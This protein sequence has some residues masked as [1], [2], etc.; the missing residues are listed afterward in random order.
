MLRDGRS[1]VGRILVIGRARGSTVGSYIIYA[2][3]QNGKAPKAIIVAGEPDPIIIT[4]AI[5]AGIPLYK[6]DRSL[7]DLVR[8]GSMIKIEDSK[9]FIE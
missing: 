4:G 3:K 5:L 1:I 2:L 8:D 7:M 9:I 6:S